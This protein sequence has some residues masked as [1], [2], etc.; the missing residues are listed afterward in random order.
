MN[1]KREELRDAYIV[2]VDGV[3]EE[4]GVGIGPAGEVE[5][6]LKGHIVTPGFV[7]THHHFYQSL[8]R[9]VKEVASA[10]LFDWLVFLYEKW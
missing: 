3:I 2:I 4:V 5:I 10:K 7:N 9:S 8:F 6:D 1:E